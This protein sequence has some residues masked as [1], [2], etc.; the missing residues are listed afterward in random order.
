VGN[1]PD[2]AQPG[3]RLLLLAD[4]RRDRAPLFLVHDAYG[5]LLLYRRLA[6][7]LGDR[8]VLGIAPMQL[9]TGLPAVT[10]IEEMAADYVRLIRHAWPDGPYLLGG[11]CAGAVLA[12]EMALVLEKR[13]EDAALVAVLDAADVEAEP[14]KTST[15]SA[16]ASLATPPGLETLWQASRQ[17]LTEKTGGLLDR[18]A[19]ALHDRLGA[20][21][22]PLRPRLTVRKVYAAAD[23]AV[24]P[25]GKLRGPVFLMRA[26]RGEGADRPYRELYVDP[27]LGWRQRT[28][29]TFAVEDLPGGHVS[30]LT[31]PAVEATA[32]AVRSA[33]VAAL[34]E[35]AARRSA[36]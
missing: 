5:D 9:A 1:L 8:R 13:G 29:G 11:L 27:A 18:V 3:A 33:C 24:P 12:A 31:E 15:S 35:L 19:Y 36:L 30:L 2:A 25:L 34:D 17:R 16:L 4:G 26:T 22:S 10:R 32:A 7:A 14:R 21:P 20:C 28:T 6:H 23:R